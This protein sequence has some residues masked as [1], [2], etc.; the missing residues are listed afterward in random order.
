MPVAAKLSSTDAPAP[1]KFASLPET[2]DPS[3]FHTDIQ[4]LVI[5]DSL[6][7]SVTVCPSFPEK[8]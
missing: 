8:V 3:G 6:A 5:V 4:P 7:F 1:E 2:L